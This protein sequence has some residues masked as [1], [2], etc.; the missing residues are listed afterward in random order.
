MRITQSHY[1][2]EQTPEATRQCDFSMLVEIDE[3]LTED[4]KRYWLA[5]PS[6]GDS[7]RGDGGG[8]S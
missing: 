6:I 7:E 5:Q 1:K 3:D 2:A 4:Q 8:K